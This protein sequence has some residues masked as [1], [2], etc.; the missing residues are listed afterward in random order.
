MVKI[1]GATFLAALI[2]SLFFVPFSIWISNK[3]NVL[4]IPD[5]RKVH[6]YPVPRWGGLGIA[7]SFF[8]A[9][10]FTYL[11]FDRFQILL[12]YKYKIYSGQDMVGFLSLKKQFI[13]ILFGSLFVLVLGMW[14]DKTRIS[15]R[16]KFPLQVIA[17]YIA[18]D[19]GVRLTGISV[20]WGNQY[21]GFPL[22]AS[23]II[24]VLWLTGFMNTINL[25]DG[26]DGLA[27]GICAIAAGTFFIVAMLQGQ[28]QVVLFAKQ[29]KLAGIISAALCGA[30][31]GFVWFNFSPAKVFMGDGGALFLG[32]LLA[33]I[34]VIGT[35]KTTAFLSLIIPI[36]V[37]ALPVLDVAVSIVRRIR[38]GKDIFEADKEHLHHQLLRHGWNQ[39]EIVLGVYVITLIL[40]IFSILLTVFKGKV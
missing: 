37:V 22:I 16:V 35:L 5:E 10:L 8:F 17:A 6:L 4:D 19:Y 3:F 20:P 40:S 29:L 36:V 2:S 26:L 25:V 21:M 15:A 7:L 39:R 9:L 14:D 23:Q 12:S 31:T 33:T 18:M 30:V 24:T 1:Y 13:G 32:Y 27:A 38:S 28:T 34:T 11:F